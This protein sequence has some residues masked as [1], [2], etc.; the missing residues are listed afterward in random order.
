NNTPPRAAADKAERIAAGTEMTMAHGLAATS[1]VADRYI[2][3]SQSRPS[4]ENAAKATT[5]P[6][7]T[8]S[9]YRW[10]NHALNRSDGALAACAS[11][12]SVIMRAT[13]LSSTLRATATSS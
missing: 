2:A 13:V 5:A 4:Q 12:T 1:R 7:I 9:V 3:S 10:P 11:V 6:I 8:A